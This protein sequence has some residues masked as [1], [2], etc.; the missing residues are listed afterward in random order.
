[1]K[2]E[3]IPGFADRRKLVY[4]YSML[5]TYSICAHQMARRYIIKDLGPFVE[6]PA[7]KHGNEVHSAMEMRI[8]GG[9][10]LPDGMQQYEPFAAVFDGRN[11]Q[12]E[13]KLA[14]TREG[15]PCDYY[16]DKTQD[17]S[18]RVWLRGRAD[19]LVLGTDNAY[20]ADHKTGSDKFEDPFELEIQA[21][22]VK[23]KYPHLTK[24]VGQYFWLKNLRVGQLYDLSDFQKTWN[25]VHRLAAAIE[26]DRTH[27]DFE[28]RQ[29][30]LCGWCD[31]KDCENWKP[32]KD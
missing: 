18:K 20:L 1:M 11:A 5:N 25:E 8:C 29:S 16:G 21:L 12:A 28:K 2:H 9:K 14:I 26:E 30:G 19:V 13:P 3:G 10:P 31:V 17:V 22:M 32:R 24:I 27:E 7:M 15:H 23:A 6:T 4:T